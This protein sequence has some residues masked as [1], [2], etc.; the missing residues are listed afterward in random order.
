MGIFALK[1]EM[2]V[3]EMIK[4]LILKNP[5]YVYMKEVLELPLDVSQ[6][7]KMI[8]WRKIAK[9]INEAKNIGGVNVKCC[10]LRFE[11]A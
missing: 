8:T 9:M 5:N 7:S 10:G 4:S 11:S 2:I 3:T 1:Q 6:F